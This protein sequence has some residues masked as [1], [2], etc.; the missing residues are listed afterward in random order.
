MTPDAVLP[1]I[2]T[3]SPL[4]RTAAKIAC[5]ALAWIFYAALPLVLA[6]LPLGLALLLPRVHAAVP[7]ALEHAALLPLAHTSPFPV[8]RDAVEWIKQ[9]Y[10]WGFA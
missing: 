3:E 9:P 4:L 1:K 10:W 5:A 2:L 7:L 6:D 8:V